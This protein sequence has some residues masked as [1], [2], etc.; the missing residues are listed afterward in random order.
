[1]QAG[2]IIVGGAGAFIFLLA[3]DRTVGLG[4]FVAIYCAV[5]FG[6]AVVFPISMTLATSDVGGRGAYATALCSCLQQIVAGLLAAAVALFP[7][8][9]VAASSLA[10]AL[11]GLAAFGLSVRRA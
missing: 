2:A 10:A 9:N 1:M 4:F 6:Q 5:S 11:F 8:E 3:L 7:H